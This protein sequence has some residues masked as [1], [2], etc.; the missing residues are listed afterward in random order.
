MSDSGYRSWPGSARGLAVAVDAAVSAAPSA[1]GEAFGAAITDLA[2][3][4]EE[5]LA[6]VLGTVTRDLLERA[7]PDGLDSD[8]AEQV[9]QRVIN[10]AASW[11]PD[12]DSDALIW[13]LTG[14]LG[15]GDLDELT[16]RGGPVV[17]AHGL[18]LIGELLSGL[19]QPLP[20]VLE[21]AL[22]ELKRAQ[23]IELP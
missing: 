12:L 3:V 4:D 10:S 2:R 16:E 20:P 23:T 5:Q 1:D 11:Y 17:A 7:Y 13:A 6:V 21:D 9:L 8:D 14:A 22:H 15:I 18:L 19:A